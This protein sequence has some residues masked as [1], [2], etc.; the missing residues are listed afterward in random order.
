MTGW[1]PIETAPK[2]GSMFLIWD[3]RSYG[4]ASWWHDEKM[5]WLKQETRQGYRHPEDQEPTHWMPLPP[6]PTQEAKESSASTR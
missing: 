3:G 5:H 2:D 1:Q 6:P 4:F